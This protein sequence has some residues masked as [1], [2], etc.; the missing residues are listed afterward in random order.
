MTDAEFL[1]IAGISPTPEL[2]RRS[3]I[4]DSPTARFACYQALDSALESNKV[5]KLEYAKQSQVRRRT[6]K[7]RNALTW[8]L[9]VVTLAFL[10]MAV[11][12][13]PR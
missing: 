13:W 8:A 9:G 11:S 12:L 1:H 6:I 2:A 7:Q 5:L 4:E 3:Q 10:G